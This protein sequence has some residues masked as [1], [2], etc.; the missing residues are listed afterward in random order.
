ML[1]SDRPRTFWLVNITSSDE[2]QLLVADVTRNSS[3]G[4]HTA[5]YTI[6]K[7]G[8]YT[9]RVQMLFVN[10][11]Q[12]L[13]DQNMNS[14]H[15]RYPLYQQ[16]AKSTIEVQPLPAEEFT[17]LWYGRPVCTQ[18]VLAA[19]DNRGFWSGNEWHPY[20]CRPYRI[21]QGQ[22]G[23]CLKDKRVL[24]V[25]DSQMRY[26][27]A[28]ML[29]WM[30]YEDHCRYLRRQNRHP[31]AFAKVGLNLPNMTRN[32]DGSLV[33]VHSRFGRSARLQYLGHAWDGLAL[34]NVTTWALD[35]AEVSLPS[36]PA[37]SPTPSPDGEEEEQ[38][39][40]FRVTYAAH[41]VAS[42]PVFERWMLD[43]GLPETQ[44]PFEHVF[45]TTGLHDL[46]EF[47]NVSSFAASLDTVLI[48]SALKY[49]RSRD[50]ITWA[51]IWAA[52]E[53]KKLIGQAG[54]SN[55]LRGHHFE[56]A[57]RRTLP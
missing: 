33:V 40:E 6:M 4:V 45:I 19:S 31:L 54:F 51:G 41:M 42:K 35:D 3:T 7:P 18:A 10:G 15:F 9:I 26:T 23:R 12:I 27:L 49:A 13:T 37:S 52:D 28:E 47:A 43:L 21:T 56:D 38:K 39:H 20:A 48:P 17:R 14:N 46:H 5:C 34:A 30:G 24:I 53:H 29:H 57:A 16:I 8:E 50:N 32:P 55:N 1:F 44:P 36:A 11:H 22:V 25:G 2:S